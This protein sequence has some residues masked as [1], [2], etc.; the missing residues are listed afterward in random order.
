MGKM[1]AEIKHDNHDKEYS[2][3]ELLQMAVPKGIF[4]SE[5]KLILNKTE[6]S[7]CAICAQECLTGALTVEGEKSISLV[8]R[9][10]QECLTGALTVEGEKSISLV[11]RYQKCDACGEC[12]EICPEK[13]LK[14]ESGKNESPQVIL[15]E[16]EY[17]HCTKCGVV[18][19]SKSMIKNIQSKFVNSGQTIMENLSRCPACKGKK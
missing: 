19:G 12:V 5:E 2:R 7:G 4:P 13:C 6:C 3:R 10:Q 14:L 8:F 18:I 11:F 17:A 15:F 1:K 9:Y 16:D